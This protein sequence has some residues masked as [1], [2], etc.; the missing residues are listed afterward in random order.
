[1]NSADERSHWPDGVTSISYDGI[2]KLGVDRNQQLYWDG[3]P[4]EV[5]RR[6]DLTFWQKVLG[7]ITALAIVLGGIG[8]FVQGISAAHDL[9]CKR[10][11]LSCPK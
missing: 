9:G 8:G 5:K 7:G 3:K 4:V 1:M 6:L 11:W 10:I 2:G